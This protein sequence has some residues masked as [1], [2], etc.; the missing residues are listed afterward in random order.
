MEIIREKEQD[1]LRMVTV[2]RDTRETRITLSL[3]LDGTGKASVDTGIGFFN[4]ML[5][6]FFGFAKIGAELKVK[7]DTDVDF[8]HSA[9]DIGIAL[10]EAFKAALGDKR[11]IMRYGECIMPMD[12][13]LVMVAI[14][15]SGRS[16]LSYDLPLKAS[17]LNDDGEE[18]SA[19]V[20]IFDTELVEEF[21]TA[22]TRSAAMTIHVKKISGSNTHHTVEAL[23]KGL[24]R[25]VRQAVSLDPVY[26]DAVPSTKGIL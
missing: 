8:H 25:A 23:F 22:L 21:L 9:E 3:N 20:G 14:D 5:N 13:A 26:S 4:H 11:G 24:G 2:K 7:G 18:T 19:K 17:R 6:L 15:F 1:G 10:G 16:Y 12:E